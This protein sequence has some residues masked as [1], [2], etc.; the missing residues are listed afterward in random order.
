MT[1][2]FCSFLPPSLVVATCVALASSLV[3]AQER[4]SSTVLVVLPEARHDAMIAALRVELAGHAGVLEGACPSEG[5]TLT[6]LRVAA[7]AQGADQVVWVTFP[8][9]EIAP[10]EV[11]VLRI[12]STRSREAMLPSAWDVIEPR[13]MAAVTASLVESE[14]PTEVADPPPRAPAPTPQIPATEAITSPPTEA[15]V[16]APTEDT[17]T[18]EESDAPGPFILQLGMAYGHHSGPDTPLRFAAAPI[19]LA[20]YGQLTEWAALGIRLR[21][22]VAASSIEGLAAGGL[23]G[24]PSL[25][26]T[27]HE[28]IS[29]LLGI[30]W[31]VHVDGGVHFSVVEH[32][33]TPSVRDFSQWSFGLGVGAYVTLEIGPHHGIQID[34]DINMYGFGE[35]GAFFDGMGSLNYVFRIE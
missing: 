28:T 2:R 20:F 10:A 23:L 34:Y 22:F 17:E 19:V 14:E 31:G 13:V 3:H 26:L 15:S 29:S 5:C 1:Q 21:G 18:P 35:R 12:A 8:Q 4:E 16:E 6:S 30:R 27:L 25:M 24:V 7:E 9:G 32:S 11:R 33:V